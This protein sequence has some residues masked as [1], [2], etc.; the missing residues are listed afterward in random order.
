MPPGPT[1][2]TTTMVTAT[3][4][5][6]T[7]PR[8][9]RS[10]LPAVLGADHADRGQPGSV[11]LPRSLRD[12]VV[13]LILFG[14]A[15]LAGTATQW[16]DSQ[17]AS[18]WVLIISIVF[19]L[20]ACLSL[21]VRRDRPLA[22]ALVAIG[23]SAFS[24]LAN[25]AGIVAVLTVA[26]YC[27]PRRTIQIALLS[28]VAVAVHASLYGTDGHYDV[29]EL[30]IGVFGTIA[31]ASFGL[32]VRARRELV[33]SL[34]ERNRRLQDEQA[35]RVEEARR[36]ERNRIAREMHDVLAH[37]I[38]LLSLHAGALEYNPNATPEEIARAVQVIRISAREAQEELREVIGVLR[39]DV[40]EQPLAAPQ[41]T[42]ADVPALVEES[43]RAGMAVELECAVGGDELPQTLG[44]TVYRLVQ[45]ALTNV[46]KHAP[47]QLVTIEVAG[48]P[49]AGVRVTVTNRPRVG[50]AD[51]ARRHQ[52]EH[53]GSG[54]GLIGLGERVTLAGGTLRH[55]PLPGGGFRLTAEL[56][57]T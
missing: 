33:L 44:R 26:I 42:I 36:A 14:F 43:R 37:R 15:L 52:P 1:V 38:S 54:A 21:W 3:G 32:F 7:M 34:H 10:L 48:D 45:E 5:E 17:H 12:W 27:V 8:W 22:V 16:S 9:Q 41:P 4:H 50:S 39:A 13:D 57:W 11:H 29:T 6:R 35:W 56:P 51:S 55:G 49:N 20:A 25:N 47:G 53:V 31:A 24:G 19:G 23:A 40:V 30:L 46:R 28:F 2:A 18:T